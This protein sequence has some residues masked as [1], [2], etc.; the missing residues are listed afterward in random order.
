MAHY[1]IMLAGENI[2]AVV[3]GGGE[4]GRRRVEGLLA[5]GAKVRVVEL[6]G[7]DWPAGVQCV[8]ENYRAEL[9]AGAGLVFACTNDAAVNA[10]IAA[11]ARAAA[12]LVNRA[13]DP[14][15]SDFACPAVWR[16]ENI[17]LAVATAAGSPTVA[18]AL[19][20]ELAAAIPAGA[21]A[22]AAA[23]AEFRDD[24][25]VA[26][27]DA[28]RRAAVLRRLGGTEGFARFRAG[29]REAIAAWLRKLME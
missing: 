21:D 24:V 12:A 10:R 16:G 11:D 27:A 13:D 29:G 26:V 15:D 5:A 28:G 23:V 9:L 22:F 3:V 8:P 20:D 2:L 6:K 7:G 18:A 19:R 4:V 1:P 25:K 14:A 17:V